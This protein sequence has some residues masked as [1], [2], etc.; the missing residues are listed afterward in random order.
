MELNGIQNDNAEREWILK[1]LHLEIQ[2]LF[3]LPVVNP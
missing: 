1:S 2:K 3:R